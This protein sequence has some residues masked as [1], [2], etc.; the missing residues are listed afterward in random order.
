MDRCI[1]LL[2]AAALLVSA[3]S[4]FADGLF[5]NGVSPRSI[6]RGGTNQGFADNGAVIFDNPAAMTRV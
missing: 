3:A 4:A 1:R 6:G 5:L 2:A